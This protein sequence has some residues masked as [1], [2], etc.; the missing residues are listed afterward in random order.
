MTAYPGGSIEMKTERPTF[1]ELPRIYGGL[2]QV[3]SQSAFL[4]L[5]EAAG[6]TGYCNETARP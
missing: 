2:W 1:A 4:D 5:L 3:V 6:G